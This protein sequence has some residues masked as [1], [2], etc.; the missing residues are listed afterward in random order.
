MHNEFGVCTTP[1]FGAVEVVGVVTAAVVGATTAGVVVVVV[2]TALVGVVT[3][4]SPRMVDRVVTS[5]S[6]PAESVMIDAM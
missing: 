6:I 3:A 1:W 2:T 4:F 5:I